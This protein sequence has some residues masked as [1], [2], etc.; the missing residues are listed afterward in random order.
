[1][2]HYDVLCIH[3]VYISKNILFFHFLCSSNLTYHCSFLHNTFCEPRLTHQASANTPSSTFLRPCL[4]GKPSWKLFSHQLSTTISF[5]LLSGTP[6]FF[7]LITFLFMLL[8]VNLPFFKWKLM[9]EFVCVPVFVFSRVCLHK[10]R[11][12]NYFSNK[13]KEPTSSK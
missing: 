4:W 11:F 2:L 7:K 9:L 5:F 6:W 1:M 13:G 8:L 10:E 12:F 3:I